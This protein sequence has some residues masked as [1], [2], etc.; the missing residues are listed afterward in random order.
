VVACRRMDGRPPSPLAIAYALLA[1]A[2]CNGG[3]AQRDAP[4]PTPPREWSVS[5]HQLDQGVVMVDHGTIT[6]RSTGEVVLTP[7][8][9]PPTQLRAAPGSLAPLAPLLVAPDVAQMRSSPLLGEGSTMTLRIQTPA[10]RR[11]WS[12]GGTVPP[13]A[14]RIS[15]AVYAI[16]ARAVP[17]P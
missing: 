9:A 2:A 7:S 17:A 3:E 5:V 14:A 1:I 15:T 11:S 13:A 8:D 12:F 16:R 6:V 4:P 10:G